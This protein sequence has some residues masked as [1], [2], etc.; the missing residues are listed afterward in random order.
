MSDYS[1]KVKKFY[2]DYLAEIIFSA[3]LAVEIMLILSLLYPPAIG[4]EIDFAKAFQPRPEW[5]FL[6][7][8]ELV[9]YFPGNTAVIGAVAIPIVAIALLIYIP[10]IDR[11]GKGRAKAVLAASSVF[12]MF[13]ILTLLSIAFN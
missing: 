9:K 6:W 1:K 4:R 11:Y 8:F 2:P 5:Y 12:L 10:F 3:L 7:L 13:V